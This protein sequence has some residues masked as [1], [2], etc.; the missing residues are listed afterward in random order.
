MS[1]LRK[2]SLMGLAALV[3][4]TSSGDVSAAPTPPSV[5]VVGHDLSKT[6]WVYYR[7]GPSFPWA[8]YSTYHHERDAQTTVV[9][10]RARGYEAYYH[11]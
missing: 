9:E 7:K 3:L 10:L 1:Y 2:L 4:S 6:F 5:P 11:R 8:F